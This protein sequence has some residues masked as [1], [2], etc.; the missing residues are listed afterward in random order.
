[1]KKSFLLLVLVCTLILAAC[2]PSEE[3]IALSVAETK[4]AQPTITS[5]STLLPT[6]T[7]TAKELSTATAKPTNT[8]ASTPTE[9][10][11]IDLRSLAITKDDIDQILPGYYKQDPIVVDTGSQVDS[12]IISTFAGIFKGSSGAGNI[13]LMLIQYSSESFCKEALPEIAEHYN[14]KELDLPL[15]ELP[16]E[17]VLFEISEENQVMMVLCR[18]SIQTVFTFDIPNGLTGEDMV[19]LAGLLGQKQYYKIVDAGY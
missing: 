18:L 1:M 5:T 11:K 17:S 12:L 13:S 15:I 6:Y 16:N 4:T 7:P 10:Q 3:K 8:K 2:K 9:V 19:T 14:G